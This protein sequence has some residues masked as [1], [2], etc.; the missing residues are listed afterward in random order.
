MAEEDLGAG[1]YLDRTLDFEV[2]GTGDLRTTSGGEELEKDLSFQLL[3]VLDELKGQRLT[4][5]TEANIKSL[6]VDT[7][8]SDVRVEAIDRGSIQVRKPGRNSLRIDAFVTTTDSEYE[9][10]FNL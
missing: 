6:T 4:P 5:E 10:V 7:I 8:T 1:I 9:L 2:G 3:I